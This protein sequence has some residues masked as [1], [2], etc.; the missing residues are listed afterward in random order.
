MRQAA[1]EP[2]W[3]QQ[4]LP[5]SPSMSVAYLASYMLSEALPRSTRWRTWQ[6]RRRSAQGRQRPGCAGH[7]GGAVVP[8]G[9]LP[10]D[11]RQGWGATSPV[12]VQQSGTAARHG[13]A[14][15]QRGVAAAGDRACPGTSV[16]LRAWQVQVGRARRYLL[17]SNDAANVPSHRGITSEL[18]GGGPELRLVRKSSWESAGGACSAN[19][20]SGRTSATSTKGMRP[21]PCSQRAGAFMAQTGESF[22]VAAGFDRGS[23]SSDGP[24]RAVATGC[25]DADARQLCERWWVGRRSRG[26]SA[27]RRERLQRLHSEERQVERATGAFRSWASIPDPRAPPGDASSATDYDRD[28]AVRPPRRTL[29]VTATRHPERA[30]DRSAGDER[31]RGR[32]TLTVVADRTLGCDLQVVAGRADAPGDPIDRSRLHAMHSGLG[33]RCRQRLLRLGDAACGTHRDDTNTTAV[34]RVSVIATQRRAGTR[35][36]CESAIARRSAWLPS[37][38]LGADPEENGVD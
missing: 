17:D 19:S 4:T 1:T 26:L 30:V 9:L 2:A 8:A 12:P 5:P 14:P 18:H 37:A 36:G 10:P 20:A 25:D 11:H 34:E 16:W 23:G 24:R 21:L 15:P 6:R 13:S 27:R 32:C 35:A 28:R 3:F 7:R 29:P 33:R 38:A 22:E 31:I